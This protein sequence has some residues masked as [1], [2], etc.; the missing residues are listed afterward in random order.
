[1][2]SLLAVV[3]FNK[4]SEFHI[5]NL[6]ESNAWLESHQKSHNGPEN[7]PNYSERQY[8]LSRFY[9]QVSTDKQSHL[10]LY[11]LCRERFD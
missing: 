6:K 5:H 9:L 2:L 10:I 11:Q 1:M 8:I 4:F 7:D 3:S